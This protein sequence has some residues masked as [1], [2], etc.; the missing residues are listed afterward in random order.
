VG[1]FA[2]DERLDPDPDALDR[3]L[4]PGD[5][6]VVI[7]YFGRLPPVALRALA[8]RRRDVQWIEDRAQRLDPADGWGDFLIYSPRK[9]VGVPDGGVV[10]ARGP[11]PALPAPRARPA[12]LQAPSG[13]LRLEDDAASETW[14]ARFR[15]EEAAHSAAPEAISRLTRLL[16]ERLPLAPLL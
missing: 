4:E 7:D 6:V 11:L 16:L 5:A 14:F 12:T 13:L 2:V 8:A 1:F 15:E 3:Q 10:V 9:L